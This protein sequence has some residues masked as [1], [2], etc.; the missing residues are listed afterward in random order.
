VSQ[1]RVALIGYGLS[2]KSFHSPLI[3]ACPEL[4]I[5]AVVSSRVD[6]IKK[7]LPQAS[8]VSFEQALELSDLVV[9]TT[10][11]QL[12][13]E[14]AKAAL[15]AGKHVVV[16]KPFTASTSEAHELFK[17]ANDKKLILKV[18]FNRRFDADFLTLKTL[19]QSGELGEIKTIESHFDRFRP[20]P[21]ENAWREKAGA[22]SG[23]WWDLG[24]HLIDQALSLLGK[25][26][27]IIFDIGKQRQGE[28]D[29]FFDVT[30]KYEKGVRFHLRASCIVKDFGHRFR[31]HGTKGSVLFKKLD[32]QEEQLRAGRSPLEAGFGFYPENAVEASEGVNID[33]KPGC[34]LSFYRNLIA[35]ITNGTIH[36][37]D[38]AGI[39]L[40]T[41]ILNLEF[42]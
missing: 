39:I 14:Q 8:I 11:H 21:K 29:D 12:H 16:E 26:S 42:V 33:L 20:I 30:M 6:E 23:I 22:Q 13:F 1:L 17:I 31:V 40:G 10:P 3:K 25:P 28:A 35:S 38:K 7:D 41:Q 27:D 36:N 4:V 5:A 2:G 18:F 32:V 9:I 34:Y 24:P 15:S 19:I 37:D